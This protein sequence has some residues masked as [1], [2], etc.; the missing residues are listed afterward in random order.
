MFFKQVFDPKIAQYSYLVGCQATGEALVI[1]PLRDIDQYDKIAQAEGLKVTAAADTHIHADYISG[2][3]EYAERGIKVYASDEGTE[4]WK[5]EWLLNS[6]KYNYQ[7]LKHGDKFHVG[8][9]EVEAVHTPGHTPEHLI[10]AV[11]DK[12][13]GSEEPMGL[14][15]GD[16]IFVGD[17]GRPDLLES[18]AGQEGVMEPSAKEL[19]NTLQSIKEYPDH[20]QIWPGHGAGSAC[21]KALGA[22]PQ[23]T[24]GYERRHNPGLTNADSERNFVNFIL[25]GQPEPP[26]YF[27]RMKRDNK[28]GPQVLNEQLPKPEKLTAEDL[29]KKAADKSNAVVDAR[30]RDQYAEAHIPGSLLSPLNKAFNTIIGSFVGEDEDL[31][32]IIDEDK[33]EE[34]IRDL[35]RIGLDRIKGYITPEQFEEYRQKGGATDSLKVKTF[36]T[37]KEDLEKEDVA[38]VDVRK[39]AD[40][41]EEHIPESINAADSRLPEYLSRIPSDKQLYVHCTAGGRSAVSAAYLKREGY[42]NLVLIDDHFTNWKEVGETEKA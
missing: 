41:K 37:A 2:L 39:Y 14:A 42:E 17:L 12:G 21:G 15:T 11:T 31:Y 4:E 10:Y 28:E 24:L 9:I 36:E 33:K 29:A 40:H 35:I 5:Y 26:M 30:P 16:F 22:V 34:A 38:V 19:Y 20:L 18:A 8:N 3:R 13:G 25:E 6:N 27:A 23:T 32:L 1:D 7:L